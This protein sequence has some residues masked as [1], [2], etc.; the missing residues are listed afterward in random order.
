MKSERFIDA[1]F[2]QRFKSHNKFLKNNHAAAGMPDAT[3]PRGK[4]HPF[5]KMAVT[6]EP[7]MQFGCSFGI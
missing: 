6:F 3:P 2:D 1:T 5:S 7:A 4:F